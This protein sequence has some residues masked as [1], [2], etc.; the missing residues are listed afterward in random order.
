MLDTKLLAISSVGLSNN[1]E[2]GIATRWFARC[3]VCYLSLSHVTKFVV[4]LKKGPKVRFIGEIKQKEHLICCS[5]SQT[6]NPFWPSTS[7]S[8]W[9]PSF[10]NIHLAIKY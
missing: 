5:V 3:C 10:Y 1:G 2:L 9:Q 6:F 8:T 7:H 4:N